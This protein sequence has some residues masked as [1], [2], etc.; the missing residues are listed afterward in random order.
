MQ[1]RVYIRTVPLALRLAGPQAVFLRTAAHK[2]GI[3]PSELLRRILADV[4]QKWSDCGWYDPEPE[5]TEGGQKQPEQ[6]SQTSIDLRPSPN[7]G[8]RIAFPEQMS[9]ALQKDVQAALSRHLAE[10][11]GLVEPSREKESR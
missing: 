1:K 8:V 6:A 3:N 10:L 7:G 9:P 2:L 4:I 11:K 5:A